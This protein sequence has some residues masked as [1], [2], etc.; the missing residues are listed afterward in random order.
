MGREIKAFRFAKHKR[1]RSEAQQAQL[2]DARAGTL[3]S[4]LIASDADK[5]NVPTSDLRRALKLAHTAIDNQTALMAEMRAENG[6]LYTEVADLGAQVMELEAES[7]S[8]RNEVG[9]LKS[10]RSEMSKKLHAVKEKVRRFPT[11]LANNAKK[12]ESRAADDLSHTPFLNLKE[13]GVIP[14]D[15]RDLINDLVALD[16]VRPHRV[17][18]V[19][20][21]FAA[22]LGIPVQ[23]DASDRSVRRVVKEGGVAAQMQFVEAVGTSIGNSRA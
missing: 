16:G 9:S 15:T 1:K 3:T 22:K 18:G 17:M 14:D 23:G 10:I 19:L 13:K 8:L 5:E 20:K 11:R 21:R 7:S 12:A 6:D 2:Q 4:S